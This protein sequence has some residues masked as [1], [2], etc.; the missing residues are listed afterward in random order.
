[1]AERSYNQF[2]GLS[3]ALDLI[4]ER[5]TIL[6]VRELMSGPKR[7]TDLLD[8]LDGIGTSLLAQ[9]LKR[10]ESSSILE[11]RRLGPPAASTV[12]QLT[13]TGEELADALTPL[14]QWGLRH[15]LPPERTPEMSFQPHWALVA[16]THPA[17]PEALQGVDATYEFEVD[18]RTALLQVR[19]GRARLAPEGSVDAPAAKVR[20]AATTVAALGAGRTTVEEATLAG[21]LQFEGDLDAVAALALAFT[22]P[23]D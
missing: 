22:G 19:D 12:Y 3:S 10:L 13:A 7:Y 2:C 4:G 23:G 8:A 17:H 15:A 18:G 6:V 16:F 5:W 20:L 11:K 9:R 21:D 1:M 14:M